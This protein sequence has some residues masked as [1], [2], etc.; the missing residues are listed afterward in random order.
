[1]DYRFADN[2]FLFA[3]TPRATTGGMNRHQRASRSAYDEEEVSTY[4]SRHKD[5]LF[6][7]AA[8]RNLII[9]PTTTR[10]CSF[11][12]SIRRPT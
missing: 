10:T 1:M 11:P 3:S 6:Q 2:I 9:S 12:A 5:R 7:P 8:A 4:G